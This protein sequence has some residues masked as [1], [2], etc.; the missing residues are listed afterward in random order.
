MSATLP[1]GAG[2]VAARWYKKRDRQPMLIPL[3]P[4]NISNKYDNNS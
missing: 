1:P 4:F 3:N 2:Y